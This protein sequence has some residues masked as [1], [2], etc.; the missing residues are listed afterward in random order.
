VGRVC[1]VVGSSREIDHAQIIFELE[2]ITEHAQK[3]AISTPYSAG[4][5]SFRA[6]LFHVNHCRVAVEEPDR[7]I[8]RLMDLRQDKR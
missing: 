6:L 2:K 3:R 4:H 7:R 5:L 1:H 8:L